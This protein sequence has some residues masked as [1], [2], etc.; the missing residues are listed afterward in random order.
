MGNKDRT[1]S[2]CRCVN[3][4]IFEDYIFAS[5]CHSRGRILVCLVGQYVMGRQRIFRKMELGNLLD[6]KHK[7]LAG[8][9]PSE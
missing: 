4:E 5:R 2:Y 8:A 9:S 7:L 6:S 1:K 3:L